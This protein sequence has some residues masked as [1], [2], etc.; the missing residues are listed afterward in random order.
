V[1]KNLAFGRILQKPELREELF[2]LLRSV[3]IFSE[4]SQEELTEVL[5]VM[6]HV[7]YAP[8][9]VVFRQESRDRNLHLV[10]TGEIF[11]FVT[12]LGGAQ[13]ILARIGPRSVFGEIA[14][15]TGSPRTA[16][17]MAGPT[18]SE[19][20]VMTPEEFN[21][22]L[23]HHPE[24]TFKTMSGILA[25][26]DKRA[27]TLPRD[28]ANYSIWGYMRQYDPEKIERLQAGLA[29]RSIL[30]V[31]LLL[32]GLYAGKHL[33]ADLQTRIPLVVSSIIYFKYVTIAGLG[34]A[35]LVLGFFLGTV[36]DWMERATARHHRAD[37]ACMN[38]KYIHWDEVD[39]HF[40]CAYKEL[41]MSHTKVE[42]GEDYDTYTACQ[43]FAYKGTAKIK[44]RERDGLK[45]GRD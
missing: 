44:M 4:L 31:V 45:S 5:S 20:L 9:E 1:K 38:C 3:A 21:N 7:L 33:A 24:I 43:S 28:L 27:A 25:D 30:T 39:M 19:H 40:R 35:G 16:A 12:R 8:G 22:F 23:S 18:G 32:L 2:G 29:K 42:P 11:L 13:D 10:L 15:V 17:A 37:R 6:Q 34:F 41:Q 14:F 36:W 26:I